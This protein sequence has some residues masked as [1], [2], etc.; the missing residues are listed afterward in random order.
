MLY[1]YFWGELNISCDSSCCARSILCLGD[2]SD[3]SGFLSVAYD[4]AKEQKLNFGDDISGA[5]RKAK[6][7]RFNAFEEKR[8]KEEIELQTYLNNL[9]LADKAR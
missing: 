6:R 9:I 2:L 8:I 7:R 4:L 5:L 1:A 3:L